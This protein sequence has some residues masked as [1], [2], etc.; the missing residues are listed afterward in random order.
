MTDKEY[1]PNPEDQ[2]VKIAFDSPVMYDSNN[3]TRANYHGEIGNHQYTQGG[4]V[5]SYPREEDFQIYAIEYSDAFAGWAANGVVAAG[6]NDTSVTYD[7]SVDGW[8]PKNN[9]EYYYWHSGKNMAFAACSP[10]DLAQVSGGTGS[11]SY[12][13]NG[14]TITDFKVPADAS[15]Q[16]DLMFSRRVVDQ[17]ISDMNHNA[18]NYSGIPIQFQH[19]LS[20]IRFSLSNTSAASVVLTGLSLYGVKDTGTFNENLTEDGS[21]Y[22][23]GD[24]GNV[25]PAWTGHTGEVTSTSPY[26]AFTGNVT[27]P[28]QPRYLSELVADSD[29]ANILLLLPQTL[30]DDVYLKVD[31]KVNGVANNK[32]VRLKGATTIAS[33]SNS[34]TTI[35]EWKMGTRYTYRLVY[36]AAAADQDKIYFSPR[37]DEWANAGVAV[38]D[39]AGA[40]N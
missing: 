1:T 30:T 18:D 12:G 39:L 26:V 28:N 6:F 33:G 37:S 14:L 13:A 22:V 29:D 11:R 10:A 21:N 32:T 17:T 2:K 36:S 38:I 25:K 35:N 3:A 5:Y 20:S 23:I 8:A 4:T 34:P 19:A 31:Y 24:S 7:Q 27:F 9:G 40:S 15:Q 16:F